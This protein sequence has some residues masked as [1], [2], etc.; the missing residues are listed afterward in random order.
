VKLDV[1]AFASAASVVAAA[2]SLLCALAIVAV[3]RQTWA[4]FS[5][6]FHADFS[7]IARD[8]GW[9]EIVAGVVVWGLGGYLAAAFTAWLYNRLAR[10]G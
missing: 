9:G 7:P 1:R 8:V 4:L 10:E 2:G 3:P 5:V 6:L